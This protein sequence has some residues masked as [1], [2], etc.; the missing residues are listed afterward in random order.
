MIPGET[1]LVLVDTE[2]RVIGEADRDECH[3]GDGRLHRAFSLHVVDADGA[4][5]LQQRAAPKPLWPGFWSNSCCSHPR[6]G[7]DI[8]IA[9]RRRAAEELG[10]QV[11]PTFLYKFQYQAKYQDVGSENE[12]CSVFIAR[13]NDRPRPDPGEVG[14]WRYLAA[15][16]LDVEIS[17]DESL[18]TPW[19]KMQ[20]RR[21][22][23]D[24]ADWFKTGADD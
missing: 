17:R 23:S 11:T 15:A 16:A 21:L 18:F 9:V 8:D 7:E 3:A 10:L 20:W 2:D 12:L 19:F 14:D 5:L 6:T 4:V 22:Q 13:C 24:Y 1:R